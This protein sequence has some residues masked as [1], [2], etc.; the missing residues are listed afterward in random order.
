MVGKGDRVIVTRV[1]GNHR[2]DGEPLIQNNMLSN[3]IK[4]V[5]CLTTH[6]G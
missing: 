3:V 1:G 4:R 5:R 2:I 6:N